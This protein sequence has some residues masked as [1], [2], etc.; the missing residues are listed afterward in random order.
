MGGTIMGQDIRGYV[1]QA[2]RRGTTAAGA[3]VA[4]WIA[5]TL[6]APPAAWAGKLTC[7]TGTDPA[8][9]NDLAQI[10]AVRAVVEAACSCADYDGSAGLTHAKYTACAGASIIG[11]VGSGHLRSQCTATVKKYY[12]IAT[13]GVSASKGVV[14]CIKKTAAGKVTCAIK[15]SA[16]CVDTPGKYTQAGCTGFS[17][18]VDGADTDH[19]WIVGATDSGACVATG[20]CVF[21]TSGHGVC[22]DT[23]GSSVTQATCDSFGAAW[24]PGHHCGDC[25][26]QGCACVDGVAVAPTATATSTPRPPTPTNTLAPGVP[27]HTATSTPLPN[28][29][30]NTPSS[31]FTIT[32]TASPTPGSACVCSC[33]G[34][35]CVPNSIS[36]TASDCNALCAGLPSCSFANYCSGSP[37]DC[38]SCLAHTTPPPTR[39]LTPTPL[40][41][42]T[43]T[44]TSTPSST[45]CTGRF[46]D[47]GDGTISDSQTGLMWEK[48]DQAGGVHQVNTSYV[49]AGRCSTDTSQL[50]QPTAQ[51]A[52]ACTAAAGSVL[53]CAQCGAGQGTC[54]PANTVWTWL[55]QLNQSSFAG[56]SDWRIPHVG[57][58]GGAVEL[59]TINPSPCP[60]SGPCVPPQFNTACTAGCSVTAC[61]C[62]AA[63]KYWSAI[64]SYADPLQAWARSLPPGFPP[65]NETVDKLNGIQIR[66]VR[67]GVPPPPPP[68]STPTPLPTNTPTQTPTR[69][70]T[71]TPTVT[72]TNTPTNT[73]VPPTNT[74]TFTP[75]PPT[76]T[77]TRTPTI[78]PTATFT[79]TPTITLTPTPVPRFVDNGDGTITDN[80]T[81]LMWEKKDQAGGI[82]NQYN[83]YYTWCRDANGDFV[84]DNAG[85][86]PDGLAFTGFL[87][88]LNTPPC[89]AGH[90]DWRLPTSGGIN[91]DPTGQAAELE[92]IVDTGVAG[93][94]SGS[95]PCV[96]APFN[97]NCT[98]GC[99]ATACSCT[100]AAGYT[101]SGSTWTAHPNGAWVLSFYNG[102]VSGV[103][104]AYGGAVRAVR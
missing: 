79:R 34:L 38:A 67:G 81:G 82:H 92:S 43:A 45:P 10:A 53:G 94:G 77:F 71:S 2:L 16:K 21:S 84:C 74:P 87:A 57:Q 40:P 50:C 4:V 69:T 76:N 18:C 22:Q 96:P 23:G 88:T 54:G 86:P 25:D 95:S 5:V 61:S 97:A 93:C 33:P 51:A 7:L 55:V 104:K 9:T 17:H 28:A 47:N 3:L 29:P 46:C 6:A 90:C 15:P 68:T 75:V 59:E 41:T 1:L 14:P 91:T 100:P 99:S 98:P 52:S 26:A 83:K 72:P 66:A 58:D 11:E 49:W 48:K 62:T 60:P 85:N 36:F 37:S 103:G 65:A 73:P 101:W 30:T 19:N 12:S 89:F 13:C 39:T 20:C 27:T 44:Q 42:N 56:H 31:T 102:F 78:T 8:V 35:S 24:V 32:P 63:N 70:P 64:S 80:Q